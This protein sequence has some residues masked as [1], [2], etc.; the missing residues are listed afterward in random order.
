MY[1]YLP[2]RATDNVY[3]MIYDRAFQKHRVAHDL[4]L[5]K[6]KNSPINKRAIGEE[7]P[8]LRSYHWS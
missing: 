4:L 1:E 7:A 3:Q 6:Y 2:K 5:E 8:K